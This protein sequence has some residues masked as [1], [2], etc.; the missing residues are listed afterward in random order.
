MKIYKSG[1]VQGKLSL[2]SIAAFFFRALASALKLS[3]YLLWLW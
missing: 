2:I 3:E 1:L